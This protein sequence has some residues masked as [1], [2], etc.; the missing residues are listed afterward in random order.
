MRSLFK[1]NRNTRRRVWMNNVHRIMLLGK[2][3]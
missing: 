3:S 2:D 1:Q